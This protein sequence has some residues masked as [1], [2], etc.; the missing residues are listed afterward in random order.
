[1]RQA[2]GRRSS[3]RFRRRPPQAP[4]RETSGLRRLGSTGFTL[5]RRWPAP[6]TQLASRAHTAAM[7]TSALA[8][9]SRSPSPAP[10][11]SEAPQGT[12]PSRRSSPD[13]MEQPRKTAP[14]SPRPAPAPSPP[15]VH[16]TS[17]AERAEDA[18]RDAGAAGARCCLLSSACLVD[19]A[20]CPVRCAALVVREALALAQVVVCCPCITCAAFSR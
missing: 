4:H 7:S 16:E 2:L 1:M 8:P 11:P 10:A 3:G 6:C 14:M 5:D 15:A 18:A 9:S 12:P 17:R 19:I 20:C 13:V